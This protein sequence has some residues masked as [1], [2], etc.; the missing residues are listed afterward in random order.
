M[1]EQPKNKRISE[2]KSM[3]YGTPLIILYDHYFPNFA[4]LSVGNEFYWP[5][6]FFIA[7]KRRR[8]AGSSDDKNHEKDTWRMAN[9]STSNFSANKYTCKRISYSYLQIAE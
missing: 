6:L 1:D 8:V 4:A 3:I 7:K 9:V 5:V 2:I